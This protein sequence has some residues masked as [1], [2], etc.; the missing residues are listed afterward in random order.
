MIKKSDDE[1]REVGNNEAGQDGFHMQMSARPTQS[2]DPRPTRL[3]PYLFQTPDQTKTTRALKIYQ[4]SLSL[5]GIDFSCLVC[6][7]FS[8]SL[9]FITYYQ[10]RCS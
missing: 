6:F 1:D 3:H 9:C 4:C 8:P 2:L 5:P 7:L 10:R